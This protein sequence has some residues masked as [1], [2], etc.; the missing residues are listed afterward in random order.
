MTRQML[1]IIVNFLETSIVMI[2]SNLLM[3]IFNTNKVKKAL[4]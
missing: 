2:M 4:L 1:R 3:I